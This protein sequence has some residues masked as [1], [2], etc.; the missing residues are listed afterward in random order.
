MRSVKHLSDWTELFQPPDQSI[1]RFS[2]VPYPTGGFSMP[3]SGWIFNGGFKEPLNGKINFSTVSNPIQANS[4]NDW[5][6]KQVR[7]EKKKG[8]NFFNAI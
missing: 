4:D 3:T 7:T 1:P 2:T 8:K 5:M 6:I